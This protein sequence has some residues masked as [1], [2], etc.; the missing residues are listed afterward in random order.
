MIG[1]KRFEAQTKFGTH[2]LR[3]C[4]H[5]GEGLTSVLFGLSS[6]QQVEIR[7]IDKLHASHTK[8]RECLAHT[9]CYIFVIDPR[10]SGTYKEGR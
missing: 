6:A 4:H 9:S 1:L 5:V 3:L 10:P 7:A 8:E 2:A